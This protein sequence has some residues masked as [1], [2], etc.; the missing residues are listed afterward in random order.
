MNNDILTASPEEQAT[1]VV[2]HAMKAA[3]NP[4]EITPEELD[5]W[6]K[7]RDFADTYQTAM[8]AKSAL[9]AERLQDN[10][11]QAFQQFSRTHGN[12]SARVLWL[13]VAAAAACV[14]ALFYLARPAQSP[15][16]GDS[17]TEAYLYQAIDNADTAIV[18]AMAHDTLRLTSQ[19]LPQSTSVK[20]I[21]ISGNTVSLQPVDYSQ[22]EIIPSTLTVPQGKV[23]MLELPDGSRVWL[24]ACSSLI[25]PTDFKEGEPRRVQLK[26]EAYF[27]VARDSQRPFIVDCNGVQTR[28]LGT[29][30]NVRGYAG[31]EPCVTLVKGSVEVSNEGHQ[32]KLQPCQ[33]V[34][35]GSTGLLSVD[36]NVDVESVTCWRDNRFYFDGETLRDIMIE[37]GRWYNMDVMIGSNSHLSDRLHFRGERQWTIQQVVD[38]VNMISNAEVRISGNTLTVY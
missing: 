33:S 1:S 23:A 35:V 30:F 10:T 15:S 34:T 26:G 17:N 9:L 14:A 28:V 5:E 2:E 6:L 22:Y 32:V 16:F 18:I 27:A 19:A 4:E 12:R 20:S 36:S 31:S 29:E 25:Y 7:D 8:R 21:V 24:N 11:A 3:T 13:S 37:V 38:Q